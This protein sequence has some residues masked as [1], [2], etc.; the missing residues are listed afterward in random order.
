MA[1]ETS[2]I[3]I[4]RCDENA[5]ANWAGAGQAR[6]LSWIVDSGCTRHM[7]YAR[8][9]FID[10]R[11]LDEPIQVNIANGACINAVAEGTVSLRTAVEGRMRSVQILN[12][13]HV[14][15]LAGSL[16]SVPHLQDRG[17]MTRT[18]KRG[19]MLLELDGR[20]IGE[21]KRIGRSYVLNGT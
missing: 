19:M 15:L 20:V 16:I 3:T 14:P 12:V 11:L 13:L 2:W 7:T 10:Y 6:E 5:T 21:A 18:V 9:A 4:A 17:I 1:S 8:E